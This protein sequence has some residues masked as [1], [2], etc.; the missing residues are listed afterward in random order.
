[1]E[2]ALLGC[3]I[4][5]LDHEVKLIPPV[6]VRPFAKHHKNDEADAEAISEMASCPTMGFVVVETEAQ[7][8]QGILF[9]VRAREQGEPI[10]TWAR[11]T[12]PT[13]DSSMTVPG[14]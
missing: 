9:R 13:I 6:Y 1:M 11:T 7:Q 5:K 2:H 10:N 3:E 14:I 4:S 8:A 12:L